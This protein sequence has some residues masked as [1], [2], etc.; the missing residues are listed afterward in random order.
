MGDPTSI[1][2]QPACAEPSLVCIFLNQGE[3]YLGDGVAGHAQE[4]LSARALPA[5][6]LEIEVEVSRTESLAHNDG[7][8]TKPGSDGGSGGGSSVGGPGLPGTGS[9]GLTT[10]LPNTGG[11]WSGLL[12]MSLLSVAAGAFFIA[13]SRRRVTALV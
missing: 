7:G 6:P 5:T 1:A 8:E 10:G 13:Y 4:A 12:A 3:T 2:I 9:G 11:I